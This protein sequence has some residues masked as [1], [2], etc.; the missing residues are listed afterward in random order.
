M[1]ST[2]DQLESRLRGRLAPVHLE[3]VDDSARHAGHAGAAGGGGHYQVRIVSAAFDDK[4][5]LEQHRLVYAAVGDLMGGAIH[6]LG[7]STEGAARWRAGAGGTSR[8]EENSAA[9]TTLETAEH[10]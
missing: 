8:P 10:D 7:L 2:A 6:A 4:P 9:G 3:I 1:P 5:L